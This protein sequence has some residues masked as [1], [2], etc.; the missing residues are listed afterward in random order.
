[1]SDHE[2]NAN[3]IARAAAEAEANAREY[4]AKRAA[5]PKAPKKPR[6]A[7][8]P[9]RVKIVWS[10][11]RTGATPLKTFP[12]PEREAADAEAVRIGKGCVVTPLRV[13]M[14]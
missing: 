1:M 4:K 9:P 12:Y 8:V 11:G 7:P 3:R 2:S 14:E 13:P 6:A 5:P 10:V